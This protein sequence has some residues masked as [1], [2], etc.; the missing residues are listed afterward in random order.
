MRDHHQLAGLH[1]KTS[2]I[3]S[4]LVTMTHSQAKLITGIMGKSIPLETS[5]D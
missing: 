4:R 3:V 5:Q 2:L 1:R